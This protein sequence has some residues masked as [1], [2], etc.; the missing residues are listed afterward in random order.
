M[1]DEEALL[2]ILENKP[3]ISME[4]IDKIFSID[5]STVIRHF[6][7]LGFKKERPN[8]PERVDSHD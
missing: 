7:R 5:S 1:K 6:V 2:A 3:S 8:L 4:E